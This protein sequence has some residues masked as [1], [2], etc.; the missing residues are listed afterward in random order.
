MR[1]FHSSTQFTGSCNTIGFVCNEMKTS[2]P[3][4]WQV[5][6]M[7]VANDHMML[8]TPTQLDYYAIA[9]TLYCLIHGNYTDG[10]DQNAW[11]RV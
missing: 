11:S 5:S 1:S 2:K 4:S 7:G 8:A 9:A 3:W 6:S 10:S